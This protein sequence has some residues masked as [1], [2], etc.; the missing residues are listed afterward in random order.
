[1]SNEKNEE[2]FEKEVLK[3]AVEAQVGQEESGKHED[4]DKYD[5]EGEHK[6]H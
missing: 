5:T 2:E 3:E 4:N 1:M 6:K